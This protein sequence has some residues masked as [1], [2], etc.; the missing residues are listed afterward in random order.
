MPPDPARPAPHQ[1]LELDRAYQLHRA[2]V[3]RALAQLGVE[4]SALEDATQDVFVVLVRRIA[5]FD[6]SRSW[7]NWL[8]GI[9]KGVASG[10]RRSRTRRRRL[11]HALPE[12]DAAAGPEEA[13]V[14][15]RAAQT[16]EAFLATLDAD[17]CAV[18]VLAEIEGCTGPEIAA[19]LGVNLNTAYARLRAARERF[20]RAVGGVG[21][22]VASWWLVPQR[23]AIGHVAATLA[24]AP[25]LAGALVEVDGRTLAAPAPAIAR[26]MPA[27]SP[28]RSIAIAP[29]AAFEEEVVVVDDPDPP[30]RS[31]RRSRPARRDPEPETQ[32][33]PQASE[34]SPDA[35]LIEF[36]A[37]PRAEPRTAA[38]A[39]PLVTVRASFVDR[40]ERLERDL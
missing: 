10:Y 36:V 8:W 13:L 3:R 27:S 38:R 7:T 18:F 37:P 25:V 26:S 15:R 2:M 9:A 24:I 30:R 19:R 12:P 34:S 35:P 29:V 16:L 11:E 6:R 33:E 21:P 28:A 17:R 32:P 39:C 22:K 4:P 20:D 14:R 1:E 23:F 31:T 5:D 40:L